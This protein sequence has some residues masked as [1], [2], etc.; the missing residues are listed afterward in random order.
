VKE[1]KEADQIE[2]KLLQKTDPKTGALPFKEKCR[3][4]RCL[5]T[6][7]QSRLVRIIVGNFVDYYY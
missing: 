2:E 1:H 4:R 6:I 5:S 7:R 3:R